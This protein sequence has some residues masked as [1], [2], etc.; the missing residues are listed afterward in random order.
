MRAVLGG[1]CFWCLEAVYQLVDGVIDVAPGYAG[2]HKSNPTYEQV[3]GGTTDH[4]EVV[5]IK[6]DESKLQYKYILDIFWTVHDP[7][8][9]DRQGNDIGSQYRSIILYN[10]DLQK[11]NAQESIRQIQ[12]LWNDPITTEVKKLDHFYEAEPEHHNYFSKHPNQAYCQVV[13]N[14]KLQK[15]QAKFASKLKVN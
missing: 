3:S 7:T 13:I 10:D 11:F 1:G 8:T 2:G 15:L 14:P 6:Y 12:P 5:C 9:I 4:A